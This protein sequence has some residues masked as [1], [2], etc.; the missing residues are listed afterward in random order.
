MQIVEALI[1][2]GYTVVYR[3]HPYVRRNAAHAHESKR[4]EA[5]LAADAR[6]SGR[7]HRFGAAA[8]TAMS[9]PDCFNAADLLISDVSSVV[10]DFLYSEKPFAIT[11]ML[12]AREDFVADFPVAEAGYVIDRTAENLD[13]GHRRRVEGA[14][15]AAGGRARCGR[16]ARHP[17]RARR[18]LPLAV[19][20]RPSRGA[21]RVGVR[22]LGDAAR[23]AASAAAG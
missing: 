21:L 9:L 20:A 15:R 7:R 4:I 6:E 14:A 11:A 18:L 22:L 19:L 1:A 2:R 8:S 13:A 23:R 17:A 10:P 3:P 5:L 16:G 12:G